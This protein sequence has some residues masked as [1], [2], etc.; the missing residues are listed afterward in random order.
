MPSPTP[1]SAG[2]L[3]STTSNGGATCRSPIRPPVRCVGEGGAAEGGWANGEEDAQ[4]AADMN[5]EDIEGV[6]KMRAKEIKAELDVR[7]VSYEG[8]YEKVW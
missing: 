1:G 5:K 6:A 4:D 8:I 3:V 2:A 7:G